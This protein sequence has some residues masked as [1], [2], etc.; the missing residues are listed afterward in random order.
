MQVV[1]SV[2]YFE[3]A[4]FVCEAENMWESFSFLSVNTMVKMM[5]SVMIT[6]R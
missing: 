3:A 6:L 1:V 2:S 4:F 5:M